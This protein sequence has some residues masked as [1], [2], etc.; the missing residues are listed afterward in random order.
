MISDPAPEH[1]DGSARAI[2]RVSII[3]DVVPSLPALRRLVS[4]MG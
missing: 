4:S 1:S 3:G 2:A